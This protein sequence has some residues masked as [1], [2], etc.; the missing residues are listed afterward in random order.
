MAEDQKNTTQGPPWERWS[1][2]QI[3]VSPCGIILQICEMIGSESVSQA[4]LGFFTLA[5]VT[6]RNPRVCVYDA[7][8]M[9]A[10][11]ATNKV[12]SYYPVTSRAARTFSSQLTLKCDRM[13]AR[14]HVSPDC[15]EGGLY[16][17]DTDGELRTAS[18]GNI[19]TERAEQT[20]RWLNGAASVYRTMGETVGPMMLLAAAW[21]KNARTEHRHQGGQGKACPASR[22]LFSKQYVLAREAEAQYLGVDL[23]NLGVAEGD[24]R[25][26]AQVR[27]EERIRMAWKEKTGWQGWVDRRDKIPR[28]QQ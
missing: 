8:C 24:L 17:P 20:M 2:P 4:W 23:T 28:V 15:K 13:H 21:R 5:Q 11:Y 7:A 12:R 22:N 10:R 27:V 9:L 1:C 3:I 16:H 18:G 26:S 14:N 6:G 25:A 19:N